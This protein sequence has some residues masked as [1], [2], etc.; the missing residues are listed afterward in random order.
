MRCL[1]LDDRPLLLCVGSHEPRK[2][3]LAVLHAATLLWRA[4][5]DF[6]LAF[7]GGNAWRDEEF[8]ARLAQLQAEGRP[9]GSV[10]AISD[11]ATL[12]GLPARRRLDL[13]VGQRGLRAARGGVPLRWDAGHHVRFR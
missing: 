6:R 8:T 3:H 13:P 5:R 1:G 4:G 9:V 7:V 11:E 12:G 2:N 10:R